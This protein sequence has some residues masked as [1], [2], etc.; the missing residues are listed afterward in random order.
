MKQL[1]TLSINEWNRQ[2]QQLKHAISEP[3]FGGD[4]LRHFSD[5]DTRLQA[6]KMDPSPEA[7]NLWNFLLTEEGRLKEAKNRGTTLI[8]TMKDLGTV[9]I[10][11]YSCENT[12]AFYPDGAWWIP[13]IMELSAGLFQIA[14]AM[15]IDESFCPVRAMLG[16]FANENHFP[17]PDIL[18]CS[19]GAV[20]DDFSAI[21][22]RLEGMGHPIHW[23]EIP[24]RSSTVAPINLPGNNKAESVQLELVKEELIT[25]KEAIEQ[26]TGE[27]LSDKRLSCGIKKA[28][29]LRSLLA[30]LRETVFR[31]DYA[32]LPALELLICEMFIIHYCSDYNW[33]CTIIGD[34]LDRCKKRIATKQGYFGTDAVKVFWVN[35][36]A[37]LKAMNILE[38]SGG[39]ICGSDFL[40]THALDQIP[41]DIPPLD[42]L[43]QMALADP[44][45]GPTSERAQRIIADM[46]RY[47]SEALII[48][49]IPGASH[50]AIEGKI[51]AETVAKELNLPTL[52]IEIPPLCDSM[53][54]SIRT[55]IEALVESVRTESLF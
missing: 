22:Q 49:K 32:P 2:Y 30:D 35:P 16:A 55:R 19:T 39:R 23:W 54:P 17:H 11:A 51:I 48:S 36:V 52:E 5:G 4:L 43:S 24:R 37:D 31:A 46:K 8:G 6:I 44:M 13:C 3:P 1:K 40:F 26:I 34:L 21:A 45:V 41:T 47:G 53:E 15:G 28:N 25:V 10:M 7:L 27:V 50:C 20:C 9:P 14:D 33:A 38:E 42:A 18:I 29:H 12:I